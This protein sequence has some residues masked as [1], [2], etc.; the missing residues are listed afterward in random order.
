MMIKSYNV[1]KSVI[2]LS[3]ISLLLWVFSGAAFI[4]LMATRN[5][6]WFYALFGITFLIQWVSTVS[7]Y[8]RTVITDDESI[9]FVMPAGS[10]IKAEYEQ[11]KV[12]AT[13]SA[14]LLQ[15]AGDEVT[16]KLRLARKHLPEELEQQINA[17]FAG[18][19]G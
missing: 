15:F 17:Y 9:V 11:L 19:R 6:Y 2:S 16:W 7:I 3:W 13:P 18:G 12:H 8:P 4:F 1:N 5:P 14:Y 10:I